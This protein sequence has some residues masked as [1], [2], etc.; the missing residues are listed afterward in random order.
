MHSGPVKN[1]L[2]SASL[3]C[4]V[5][6]ILTMT[7]CNETVVT[8]AVSFKYPE[9]GQT[10]GLGDDVKVELDLPK[11]EVITSATY[12]LDGKTIETKN[13]AEPLILKTA[14]LAVGYK[15]I[16]AITDNGSKKDTATINIVLN[17]GMKPLQLSYKVVNVLPHDTSSYT[18]GLEYHNGRFLESTGLEGQ[19]TLRWVEPASGKTLQRMDLD[20]QYFGEGATL[21]GDKVVMLTWK[22]N[23]GFVYD[24]KTLDQLSTF[25]YQNSRE[26]WGLCYDGSQ[27][28]KSD[29]TNRLYFLNKESFKEES[30]I[31]VYDNKG[32]VDSINELEFI[33]G[34]IYANIY[35]SDIIVVIDPKSGIVEKHIDLSGLLDKGYKKVPRD[36]NIDVLNG[37][38]WDKQGK[39]LFVTGKRW[40]KLF[41]ITLVPQ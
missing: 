14:G 19:S 25:P 24:A 5:I 9:Q 32:P 1:I 23:M 17:S 37:I 31:D 4:L 20:K 40:P 13:N 8:S 29:G 34:K 26:G 28:I 36:A 12:L 21:V 35:T 18:Q 2:K 3:L 10:F 6:G 11:G 38:A 27:L 22:G 16:T 7:S 30:A 41:E 15:I 33:N 39:R